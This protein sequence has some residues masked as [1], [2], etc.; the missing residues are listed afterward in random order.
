MVLNR[1]LRWIDDGILLEADPRHQEILVAAEPGRAVLTPG[2]KE[3]PL[4]AA[5]EAR[6]GEEDTGVFRSNAARGNYLG[7]DRVDIAYPDVGAGPG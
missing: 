2:V 3:Q 5:A 1:V 6:L 7:F 4:G